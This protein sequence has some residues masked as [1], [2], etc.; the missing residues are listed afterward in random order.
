MRTVTNGSSLV[1]YGYG[2][3]VRSPGEIV[4][5]A[6]NVS[7]PTNKLKEEVFRETRLLP[8]MVK[9]FATWEETLDKVDHALS[10]SMVEMPS[11][12]S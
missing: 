6:R 7:R 12:S 4:A 8:C 9:I 5:R 2:G 11:S 1:K 10:R 3:S